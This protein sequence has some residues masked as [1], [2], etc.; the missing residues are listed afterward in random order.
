MSLRLARCLAFCGLGVIA[1]AVLPAVL[2]AQ[3]P[4]RRDTSSLRRDTLPTRVDSARARQV[5]PPAGVDTLVV[6]TPARA[7]TMLV[8]DSIAR[9]KVPLPAPPKPDTI[10]APIARPEAPPVL[11]IGTPRVFDRT[12]LFATGALTLSDLLRRVPGLTEFTTG[13][14]GAPAVVAS[15][16]DMR[17]VRVFLDG[18]ALDPMDLR[19][20][21]VTPVNDLPLYALE[22]LRIER[23]AEEVRVYAT[24][25][26]VDRTTAYTRADIGTGDQNTNLYRAFF[27]RRYDHGE[28]LQLA[29]EQASTQPNRLVESTNSQRMM[30][31][32]GLTHGPWSW[33]LFAERTQRAR[34][35]WM[36]QGDFTQ[37]RDTVPALDSRRTLAYLRIGNGDPDL[38]KWIQLIASADAYRGSGVTSTSIFTTTTPAP[39]T[40]TTRD[41]STYESQYLLTGGISRSALRLSAAERIRV[42]NAHTSHVASGRASWEARGI[43]LSFLGEGRSY[44]DPSRLEASAKIVPLERL[45]FTVTGSRTGGGTFDRILGQD[46]GNPIVIDSTGNRIIQLGDAYASPYDTSLAGRYQLPARTNLRAEAGIRLRDVWLTGGIIRRGA[47]VLLPPA[48]FDTMYTKQT[49]LLATNRNDAVRAEGQA[50]ARTLALRGRFWRAVNVD[51]WAV[52]WGDSTGLYRPKYQTRSELY[53]QTNLLD[54]FPRGNF[55]LFASL[56]HEYRSNARF[57]YADTV[58]VAPGFRSLNFKLE[59]RIQTAVVS[60]QFR[61]LLQQVYADVPGYNMPRQTQFYGVR[62]DFWN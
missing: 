7:D 18:I 60:Y 22:E 54:R 11:E 42:G 34:G 38:G 16:G 61:N 4:V 41:S 52:A 28:A 59:I 45:A 15:Q 25:W 48:E 8:N 5:R 1:G 40:A 57:P 9:G 35:P 46:R 12:A 43:G 19:A 31:R 3:V 14:F 32:L 23:G 2:R 29:A 33:D 55:G 13:W 51:A 44:L 47:T 20:R 21:G 17:R 37:T 39:V 6:P 30:A 62:W 36:G 10:K 50:T 56:W 53:I 26:R 58:R 49:S 24:S 27:G